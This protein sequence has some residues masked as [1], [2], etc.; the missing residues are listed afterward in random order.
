L[1][2]EGNALRL[3]Q[4]LLRLLD[5]LLKLL[6]RGIRQARQILRLIDEALRLILQAGDLVVD[7]LQRARG[8]ED[9]LRVVAR[10]EDCPLRLCRR[11]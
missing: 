7:L 10:I 6:E 4:K 5:V 8:R 9:V 3:A 1:D 11:R 2:I